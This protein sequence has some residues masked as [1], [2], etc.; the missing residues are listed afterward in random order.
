MWS[1]CPP[2]MFTSPVRRFFFLSSLCIHRA[3]AAARRHAKASAPAM[4]A[5]GDC[6]FAMIGI[7]NRPHAS[8]GILLSMSSAY[9]RAV[10]AHLIQCADQ[11]CS[12]SKWICDITRWTR[13]HRCCPGRIN[14]TSQVHD[15]CQCP[16]ALWCNPDRQQY[17]IVIYKVQLIRNP[18]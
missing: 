5:S 4:S 1:H 16:N 2:R 3:S 12:Q 13:H 8:I 14:R 9:P 7:S 18:T 17:Y 6:A 15:V 10:T 11:R